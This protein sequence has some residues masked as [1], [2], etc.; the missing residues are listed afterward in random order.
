[1]RRG[2]EAVAEPAAPQV[3]FG[4]LAEEDEGVELGCVRIDLEHLVP[5]LG[6]LHDEA[7]RVERVGERRPRHHVADPL[8]QSLDVRY[9]HA[10]LRREVRGERR[11]AARARQHG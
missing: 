5:D 3:P 9:L 7:G 6:A 4:E 10:L 2:R 11:E 8:R 1:V